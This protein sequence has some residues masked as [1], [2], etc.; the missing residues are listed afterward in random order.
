MNRRRTKSKE[1]AKEEVEVQTETNKKNSKQ[2]TA[3][4]RSHHQGT[5]YLKKIV[6]RD[7]KDKCRFI[8]L[9]CS[10]KFKRTH[11]GFCENLK[12]HLLGKQHEKTLTT[13][14]SKRENI[15]AI[16]HLERIQE[17][18]SSK[19]IEEEDEEEKSIES[20]NIIKNE[21]E[22]TEASLQFEFVRFLI[23]QN[24]PFSL[25][26]SLLQ[27]MRRI[28]DQYGYET[29]N[30]ISIYDKKIN[31]IAKD[32][33]ARGIQEKYFS[34]LESSPFSISLDCGS[35][36]SGK[37][38]FGL[39][40][41]YFQSQDKNQPQTRL[42]ALLE[43]EESH[44]GKVIY[45]KVNKFLFSRKNGEILKKNFIGLCADHGSNM[46]S[47]NKSNIIL[48]TGKGVSNRFLQDFN[49]LFIV[50]D[51]AHA[52]NL[53]IEEAVSKFP[54]EV[55]NVVNGI[56]SFFSRS[57][58][59][60]AKFYRFQAK[61]SNKPP[62]EVRRY[63]PKRWSSLKECLDRILE[64]ETPLTAFFMKYG[65]SSQKEYLKKEHLL[66]LKMLSCLLGKLHFYTK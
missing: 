39:S 37:S 22:S 13:E 65:T 63:T 66:Y 11:G 25:G 57:P 19:K 47:T 36:K 16:K 23:V 32:C 28:A 14:I 43:L 29:L 41:Y 40:I 12:V 44:T 35:D 51:Y 10:E 46:I 34:E 42:L 31:F 33:M 26:T 4:R 55:L 56:C 53:V 8:C 60:K 50:H 15:E 18:S 58:Q 3:F 7:G 59:Q 1:E 20:I 17:I 54:G 5:P 24:L 2:H 6:S 38:F 61:T 9:T 49:Y 21:F 45:D 64:L 27:F 52:F 62:L 48:D 30:N